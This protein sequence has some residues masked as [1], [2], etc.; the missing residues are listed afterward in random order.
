MSTDPYPTDAEL[1]K[2]RKW[3]WELGLGPFMEYVKSLW[4]HPDWGWYQKGHKFYISTGGWSGNESLIGE[5]QRNFMF[6]S[7]CWVSSRRGGHYRFHI[8]KNAWGRRKGREP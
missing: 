2:V 7:L 1:R 5:M 4:W 8:P 6:W 3:D